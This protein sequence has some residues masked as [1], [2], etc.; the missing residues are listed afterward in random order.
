MLSCIGIV[1]QDWE[2]LSSMPTAHPTQVS[3][4]E[5]AECVAE[6]GLDS[7]EDRAFNRIAAQH[8]FDS[9][10]AVCIYVTRMHLIRAGDAPLP[11]Q[12]AVV[13]WSLEDTHAHKVQTQWRA[14][15]TRANFKK[16]RVAIGPVVLRIQK[17][18]RARVARRSVAADYNFVCDS[19]IYTNTPEHEQATK[20]A[21]ELLKLTRRFKVVKNCVARANFETDSEQLFTLDIGIEIQVLQARASATGKL[22]MQISTQSLGMPQYRE[23]WITATS[24][25]WVFVEAILHM[26]KATK[27]LH[28]MKTTS[29]VSEASPVRPGSATPRRKKKSSG[30]SIL[31]LDVGGA[32]YT[33]AVDT[34]CK[35]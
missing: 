25:Q 34:L 23:A 30:T 19:E 4:V 6:L 16:G 17:H 33:T 14:F 22:R 8:P 10:E 3:R 29:A 24:E 2:V 20:D 15:V 27:Q 13:G 12:E 7:A 18:W 1:L 26:G 9:R 35:V 21:L 31:R 5:F 11:I 32:R 28:D